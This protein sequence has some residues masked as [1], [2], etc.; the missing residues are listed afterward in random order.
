MEVTKSGL[1]TDG[2]TGTITAIDVDCI[3]EE[4]IILSRQIV[5]QS[6]IVGSFFSKSDDSGIAIIETGSN[7][8]VGLLWVGNEKA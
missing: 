2:T 8:I 1:T 5:I 3:N 4:C 7:Q 6:R